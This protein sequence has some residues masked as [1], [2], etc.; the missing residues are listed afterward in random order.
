MIP[1]TSQ[2]RK[3]ETLLPL[4]ERSNVVQSMVQ[5]LT[6]LPLHDVS[7]HFAWELRQKARRDEYVWREEEST[8]TRELGLRSYYERPKT[9]LPNG[10][11]EWGRGCRLAFSVRSRVVSGGLCVCPRQNTNA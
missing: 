2:L 1:V 5:C 10:A 6:M 9:E 7:C 3:V 11:A 8:E 4:L